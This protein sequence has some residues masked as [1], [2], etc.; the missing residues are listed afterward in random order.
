MSDAD[1]TPGRGPRSVAAS[2]RL[3]LTE[4]LINSHSTRKLSL[5]V[6]ASILET[7]SRDLEL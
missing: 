2:Q 4:K 7:P 5:E 1:C 3:L 6:A